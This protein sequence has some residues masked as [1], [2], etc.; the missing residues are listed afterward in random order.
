[1][2]AMPTDFYISGRE[3]PA[4]PCWAVTPYVEGTLIALLLV[5]ACVF[6][7]DIFN[8]SSTFFHLAE[9]LHGTSVC[10]YPCIHSSVHPVQRANRNPASP[11][12]QPVQMGGPVLRLASVPA[13]LTPS[14]FFCAL[15][16]SHAFLWFLLFLHTSL[17]LV[18]ALSPFLGHLHLFLLNVCNF[19][20]FFFTP[21]SLVSQ[22]HCFLF[23]LWISNPLFGYYSS[24]SA[25]PACHWY[26]RVA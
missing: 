1:M 8:V 19:L 23:R 12:A 17:E 4:E 2:V 13:A 18:L 25:I 3:H 16:L 20:P 21:V 5:I 22:F 24:F 14:S 6:S 10:L 11:G 9:S 7:I 15:S 26:S